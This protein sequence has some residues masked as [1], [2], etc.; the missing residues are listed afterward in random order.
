MKKILLSIFFFSLMNV[1]HAAT[2]MTNATGN[3]SASTTWAV[4]D[5]TSENDTEAQ[6]TTVGTS[7][8]VSS[9]FTP[10]AST[11]DSI[12]LKFTGRVASPSG[13]ITC[14]LFYSTSANSSTL[15]ITSTTINA[16]DIMFCNGGYAGW[17]NFKFPRTL[18]VD[19]LTGLTVA[20]KASVASQISAYRSAVG[21]NLAREVRTTTQGTPTTGDKLII[22]GENTGP[23]ARNNFTVTWD[24]TTAVNFGSTVTAT[25][26]E[27]ISIGGGGTVNMGSSP[28]TSYQMMYAG[29]RRTS[30]G[31][32]FNIGSAGSRIPATSTVTITMQSIA[33]TDTGWEDASDGNTFVYGSTKTPFVYL[34]KDSTA[35]SRQLVVLGDVSNWL[36]NDVVLVASTDRTPAHTEAGTISTVVYNAT[37]STITLQ[38]N[39]QFLHNGT[40]VDVW[41][42]EVA[43]QTRNVR[44]FGN[45]AAMPGYIFVNG[46]SSTVYDNAECK[47]IGSS[48]ANKRGF[49]TDCVTGGTNTVN[50]CAI[51]DNS[52]VNAEGLVQGSATGNNFNWTNNVIANIASAGI[53]TGGTSG[54]NYFIGGNIVLLSTSSNY[55]ISDVGG[56][57][58]IN[59]SVSSLTQHGF[60]ISEASTLGSW[61]GAISHS[62]GNYGL[63][64]IA[65][66]YAS[67]ANTTSYFNSNGSWNFEV[68]RGPIF[69]PNTFSMGNSNTDITNQVNISGSGVGATIEF[70]NGSFQSS[71]TFT[72]PTGASITTA[73]NFIFDTCAFGSISPH[74]TRTLLP[75]TTNT[76]VR[77][78]MRNCLN[79][80]STFLASQSSL[81]TGSYI[82]VQRYNRSNGDNR[83]YKPEG[84]VQTDTTIVFISTPSIRMTA[85]VSSTTVQLLSTDYQGRSWEL[86]VSSTIGGSISAWVRNSV[87]GD[88]AAYNG[89]PPQLWVHKNTSIGIMSDTVLAT[90]SGTDG[91][92]NQLTASIPVPTDNGVEEFY[93]TNSG[94]T[95]W[96]NVDDAST[97]IVTNTS[98]LSNY[99]DGASVFNG[100]NTASKTNVLINTTINSPSVFQ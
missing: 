34:M 30:N 58:G 38:A 14:S 98:S 100:N 18:T 77:I 51:H 17:V 45:T 16:M 19:G 73:G 37:G 46:T 54:T 74:P 39:L 6:T 50:G 13:T 67:L 8:I 29:I 40:I 75:A 78:I 64:V 65:L 1:A 3:E 71:T 72:T 11:I 86:A 35:T 76:S 88:G 70:D 87:A 94:T 15:E 9:T 21:T 26:Q 53:V 66:S 44:F 31:G 93:I 55:S 2:Y 52:I 48:T 89:G 59:T 92:W 68:T 7:Y 82:A 43:N 99:I 12:A 36:P 95:G 91:T 24:S 56:N 27:S 83:I 97:N 22:I 10:A 90:Y 60:T 49:E 84:L 20:A 25:T 85:I 69:V 33:S 57:Y 47:W 5:S 28:N 79:A 4:C 62:N 42:A 63:D 41:K 96:T 23:A 81:S 32:T 61:A 80:D